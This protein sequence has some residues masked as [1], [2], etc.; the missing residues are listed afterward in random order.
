[1]NTEERRLHIAKLEADNR[2]S[3]D[4]HK[5]SKREHEIKMQGIVNISQAVAIA[6]SISAICFAFIG[7]V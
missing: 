6:A 2:A 1:M 3:K 5:N 7:S 4:K